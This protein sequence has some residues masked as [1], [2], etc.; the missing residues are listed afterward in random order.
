MAKEN[1]N[2]IIDIYGRL[3]SDL[4]IIIA[5]LSKSDGPED[6]QTVSELKLGL[7]RLRSLDPEKL[8]MDGLTYSRLFQDRI[9]NDD[10]NSLLNDYK[11]ALQGLIKTGNGIWD[12]WPETGEDLPYG[13]EIVFKPKELPVGSKNIPENTVEEEKAKIV[14]TRKSIINSELTVKALRELE[15][16]KEK[17]PGNIEAVSLKYFELAELLEKDGDQIKAVLFRDK[18]KNILMNAL[19]DNKVQTI[20][21]AGSYLSREDIEFIQQEAEDFFY[22]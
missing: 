3:C 17:Q 8:T 12:S 4:E 11:S 5:N 9:K 7:D 19:I 6:S 15:D 16:L 21:F 20:D 22:E 14:T 18:G 1:I 2:K 13:D 10:I